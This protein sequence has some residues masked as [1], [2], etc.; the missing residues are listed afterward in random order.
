MRVERRELRKEFSALIPHPSSL[1]L[2]YVEDIHAAYN[3]STGRK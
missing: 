2:L 3:F 1:I